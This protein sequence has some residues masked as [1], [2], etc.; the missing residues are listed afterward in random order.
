MELVEK[1]KREGNR[2][3][4]SHQ[5]QSAQVPGFLIGHLVPDNAGRCPRNHPAAGPL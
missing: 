5:P 3:S 2:F 4:N 1:Q